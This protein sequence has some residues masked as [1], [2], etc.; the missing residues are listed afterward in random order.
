MSTPQERP[1]AAFW[2][3]VV[4]ASALLLYPLSFGPV[5]WITSRADC[6]GRI[7]TTIYQP[8]LWVWGRHAEDA[9]GDAVRS[10]LRLGAADD[11]AWVG[12]YRRDSDGNEYLDETWRRIDR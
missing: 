11:W 4:V 7:L 6:S 12:E 1:G 5:C 9:M 10:Y 8:I 2:A 3:T